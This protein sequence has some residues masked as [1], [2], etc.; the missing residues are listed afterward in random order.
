M[1]N[2]KDI[3]ILD[4]LNN[5]FVYVVDKRNLSLLYFN[6][7]VKNFMKDI[8]IGDK[9]YNK[10][11]GINTPC[12]MCPLKK[13]KDG[14]FSMVMDNN[15]LKGLYDIN[16]SEIV[17]EDEI[18]ACIIII[19]KHNMIEKESKF[20][21][22]FTEKREILMS[23]TSALSLLYDEILYI[24]VS[25][26]YV[27][28]FKDTLN[29]SSHGNIMSY[30]KLMD[31]YRTN[32]IH[33]DDIAL[34]EKNFSY[35][36]L[37]KRFNSGI[38]YV[39]KELRRKNIHGQYEWVNIIVMNLPELEDSSS[40]AIVAVKNIDKQ[41]R[42][43]QILDKVIKD[44]YCYVFLID[45]ENSQYTSF[46]TSINFMN[47]SPNGTYKDL[48]YKIMDKSVFEKD[49]KTVY[50][51]LKNISI[52]NIIEN[53]KTQYEY[54]VEFM[55]AHSKYEIKH[56]KARFFYPDN[57]KENI[58]LS[59]ADIT[60]Q[61]LNHQ[62]EIKRTI[63]EESR[64]KFLL[65]VMCENFMEIDIKTGKST[66]TYP[67]EDLVIRD[68]FAE[69]IRW[70]AD[71]VVVEEE[72]EK[73]IQD[74]KI[75]NLIENI[76]SSGGLYIRECTVKYSDGLHNLLITGTL[77]EVEYN[78]EYIFLYAQD[79]TNI[80]RNDEKN[81]KAIIDALAVAEEA[82]KVKSEFLSK[83]SHEMRTP[84]NAIIGITELAK[85]N[86][87][88]PDTVKDYMDKLDVSSKYLLSLIDD[89]L[90]MSKIENG[91]TAV[92]NEPFYLT[93]LID[94]INSMI[95]PQIIFK[96]INFKCDLNYT[97]DYLVGDILRLKQVI[98]NLLS[99]AIKFTD[100]NGEVLLSV[101]ELRDSENNAV[102]KFSVKDTG[103]GIKQERLNEIFDVFV[104]ADESTERTYGGT[105]LGLPIS[106]NL[107]RFMGGELLVKSE[108]GKGSE[109]YFILGF[110]KAKNTAPIEHED[111]SSI[112]ERVDLS[113]YRILLVEDNDINIDI[114]KELLE[115]VGAEVEIAEN[116]QLSVDMFT[117]SA[118]WYYDAVLM[119]IQ[120]PVK[121]GIEATIEIRNIKR[122]DASVIPII[123]MSAN[124]FPEDIK[125]AIQS[126]MNGYTKKPI[127]IKQL[128]NVLENA[129]NEKEVIRKTID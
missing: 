51:F 66:L 14:S 101:T 67:K 110:P 25:R 79:I 37:N 22:R 77:C 72:R 126:G 49:S 64:F 127:D 8:N 121:N 15:I 86:Y 113:G 124:V 61:V 96:N 30:N 115:I 82:S 40:S 41:K 95:Q 34:F 32:R 80:K 26:D 83:M 102:I 21:E 28:V 60:T 12:E 109:F 92:V 91:K 119:D 70:F 44:D 4:Q 129:I 81:R 93:D 18:P 75:D 104:Q 38:S 123:A 24:N 117:A 48:A 39:R 122:A 106:R 116:G 73:Y 100:R 74:F 65:N 55:S 76:N 45:V 57:T 43:E 90:D 114:A 62:K 10:I 20:R 5:I 108:F 128:Y 97:H 94:K 111:T 7:A 31:E 85:Y 53:L 98:I 63:K 118:L 71:T 54:S 78:S 50:A 23:F 112:I 88:K 13:L 105:G 87:N 17:W 16:V 103:I 69:Q 47:I 56:Y 42:I 35:I 36:S 52:S 107:V 89:I 68:D 27:D 33:P 59:I 120:M 11:I 99:N 29:E 46:F 3:M 2:N 9:C 19:S 6:T 125:N 1:N 84:L 58:I